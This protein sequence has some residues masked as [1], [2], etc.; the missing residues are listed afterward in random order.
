MAVYD[1]RFQRG[2]MTAGWNEIAED[3]QQITVPFLNQ[4]IPKLIET[5]DIQSNHNVLDV[6]AGTGLAALAVSDLIKPDGRILATDLSDDMLEI[7]RRTIEEKKI[8]NIDVYHMPAEELDIESLTFDR[9][10]SNFG[11]SFFQEQH[12]ALEEMCRV[13]KDEGR[14]AVST[15]ASQERGLVLGLMDDILKNTVKEFLNPVAPSIF[16]FGSEKTLH[17]ALVEAGFKSVKV[18]SEIH[19]A[20]YKKAEDYWEKLYRTGPE[21]REIVSNL[22]DKDL[23][24]LRARVIEEVEKYREGEKIILPS[25][26]LIATGIK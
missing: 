21:L 8:E 3:Y 24:I 15:W 9:V 17:N 1:V 20:R 5:A 4:Y 22:P 23:K 13:L 16:E 2:R 6:G 14:V 12:K 7:L 18:I 10:I 25:E 26:A 19:S 11:L